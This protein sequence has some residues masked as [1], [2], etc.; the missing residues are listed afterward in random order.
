MNLVR[1]KELKRAN[2]MDSAMGG[3]REQMMALH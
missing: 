2:E 3:W 1:E